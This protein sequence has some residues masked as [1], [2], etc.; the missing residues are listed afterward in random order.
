MFI[1]LTQ[2]YRIKFNAWSNFQVRSLIPVPKHSLFLASYAD[3][4]PFQ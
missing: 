4:Y 1:N 3:R 2:K